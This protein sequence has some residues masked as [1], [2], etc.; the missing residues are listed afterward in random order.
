MGG[1]GLARADKACF[2]IP[3]F[4]SGGNPKYN[5][6]DTDNATR[7]TGASG[8]SWN[9]GA[10]EELSYQGAIGSNDDAV[11]SAHKDIL[12]KWMLLAIER[13]VPL[14]AV[15]LTEGMR[16]GFNYNFTN[17]HGVLQHVSQV[18]MLNFGLAHGTPAWDTHP[19]D[20]QGSFSTLD[21]SN[22]PTVV[23]DG[24]LW[25]SFQPAQAK[26]LQMVSTDPVTS[27]DAALWPTTATDGGAWVK[28]H[29]AVWIFKEGSNYWWRMNMAI[30]LRTGGICS[31]GTNNPATDTCVSVSDCPDSSAAAVCTPT[32]PDPTANWDAPAVYVDKTSFDGGQP[33]TTRDIPKF[34]VEMMTDATG[35]P[36]LSYKHFPDWPTTS[37]PLRDGTFGVPHT[38]PWG[39]GEMG[40][41]RDPAVLSSGDIHCDGTGVFIPSNAL[42][43]V[44]WH[45]VIWNKL[46]GAD[47]TGVWDGGGNL[48]FID[49]T[50][51]TLRKNQ[52]AVQLNNSG[53]AIADASVIKAQFL[54]APYGSQAPGTVWAPLNVGGNDFSCVGSSGTPPFNN[55]TLQPAGKQ[56]LIDSV[57]S[58]PG[59]LAQNG[60]PVEID[61]LDSPVVTDL[62]HG[63][64]PSKNYACAVQTT[65]AAPYDWN[66]ESWNGSGQQCI[67]ALYQPKTKTDGPDTTGIGIPQHQCMQASL[68]SPGGGV[69]FATQSAFRNMHQASASLKR[70]VANIDTRGLKKIKN[71]GYHWIYLYVE[72]H[73]MPYRVDAGYAPVTHHDSVTAYNSFTAQCQPQQCPGC[74]DDSG[75]CQAGNTNDA[76]GIGGAACAFCQE[77]SSCNP[78]VGQCQFPVSSPVNRG[79][80]TPVVATPGA[81]KTAAF[82]TGALKTVVRTAGIHPAIIMPPDCRGVDPSVPAPSDNWFAKDMP[83]YIVHA[84]ADV[85]D[86]I[87]IGGQT[88]PVFQQLTSFGQFITHDATTEGNVFGWNASLEPLAGTPFQ[89]VGPSTYRIRIPNDG[90][91][92]VITRVEPLPS[93]RPTCSGTVNEDIISLLKAIAPLITI[94][95]EDAG[96]INAL[97][98]SLQI[99]CV[100]LQAFLTHI[101]SQNWGS[102]QSWIH[103]LIT[104][105]EATDGCNC[106]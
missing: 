46:A 74:V 16:V 29:T 92:R 82:K 71:Q 38:D 21:C 23:T 73:N 88:V 52:I 58:A 63:W 18:I 3:S 17:S 10:P 40:S 53:P 83:T 47:T 87:S 79:V 48:F 61:Q 15:D 4:V 8:Y 100:D 84:Y 28:A 89:K 41:P 103:Y 50:A 64:T 91:G 59:G 78:T 34:W 39:Q 32:A 44:V 106:N 68:S 31:G 19:A 55:C 66:W 2:P 86:T 76:C 33:G 105:I 97:I 95:F 27:P 7:W 12:N 30:P 26:L 80:N 14:P 11:I 75:K 6:L 104:Q 85:G 1:A 45:S 69:Q 5:K 57:P 37:D 42:N 13:R 65:D 81:F 72:T 22:D 99:E 9:S 56:N 51:G 102:W 98:D 43:T 101:D 54:I 90:A 96:E 77:G 20:C 70:E 62:S 67:D 35:V 94:D 49:K 36:G 93:K 60:S 25:K 24:S